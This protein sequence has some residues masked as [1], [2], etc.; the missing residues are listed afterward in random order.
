[1]NQNIANKNFNCNLNYHDLLKCQ[2]FLM[3]LLLQE[4]L[5]KQKLDYFDL[6]T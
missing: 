6:R 3:E 5:D 4:V 1:M 2:N